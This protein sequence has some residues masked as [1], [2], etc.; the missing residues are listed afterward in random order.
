MIIRTG[1]WEAPANV[2]QQHWTFHPANLGA[3]CAN[4]F[5]QD[6]DGD[7]DADILSSSA[8]DYGIWWYEQRQPN[9]GTEWVSHE[10]S[11]LFSQSHA[12]AVEDINGDG[13]PDMIT[14]K[15]Y[16]AHNGKD[17]GAFEPAVLY[18]RKKAV[19]IAR[20]RIRLEFFQRMNRYLRHFRRAPDKLSFYINVYKVLR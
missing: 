11:R 12:M 1:W 13:H 6:V 2:R 8:H 15:R 16:F 3:D 7:G 10:I 14:G 18:W 19:K 5:V 20:M 9:G 4:M 17:P